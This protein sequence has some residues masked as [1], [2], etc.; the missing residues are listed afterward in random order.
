MSAPGSTYRLQLRPDFLDFATAADLVGYLADLGVSHLYCSPILAARAESTHGYDV[1]DPTRVREELGGEQGLRDLAARAHAHGLGVVADLVPNH[2]GTGPENPLWEEL[3]AGGRLSAAAAVFDVDWDHPLPGARGR[4]VLP[5]LGRPYGEVLHAGELAVEAREDGY[6]LRYHEHDLPLA[7]ETVGLVL[8]AGGPAGLAGS[9]G[10]PASWSALHGLIEA[11]HYRLVH[12][13]TGGS[14]VN[15]RRF[16]AVDDLAAV[17]VEDPDV[18]ER[19][20]GTILRLVADGVLAGLRID[21]PDGL[22]DPGGY[23]RRLARRSGGVWTVAEKITEPGEVLPDW[24]V[25]GTT[26]YEFARDVLGLFV[27]PGFE[28]VVDA[29]LLEVLGER[30]GDFRAGV[31]RAKG[32]VLADD[33]AADVDRLARLLWR[34]AESR[35]EVRDTVFAQCREV[36]TRLAQAMPVYRTY[37]DP[38]SGRSDQVDRERLDR[39]VRVAAGTLPDGSRAEAVERLYAFVGDVLTG[40]SLRPDTAPAVADPVAAADDAAERELRARFPQ[41]SSAAMAK[42]LE[43]T[44]LYRDLR[45]VA[46]NEVGG[47]PTTMGLDADGFHASQ[48]ERQRRQPT[49]MLTTSTHDTKRGED[50]RLRIAAISERGMDVVAAARRWILAEVPRQFEQ[51]FEQE[52][53]Q[54]VER[55][56]PHRAPDAAMQ[57]LAYQTLLGVWPLDGRWP[58]DELRARVVDYLVKAGR[59]AAT[60]TSW[61][62]PGHAYEERLGSFVAWLLDPDHGPTFAHEL[63]AFAH[64]VAEIAIVSGLA[65]TLLRATSPGVP[66]TY[67]GTE[68]WGDDLVDP[69]N[70]RPTDF[71][72]RR[73]MLPGLDRADPAE[74]FAARR[75]G[76]VKAYVLREALRLR[77]RRPAAFGSQ[78]GYQPLPARGERADHVVAFARSAPDG[79]GAVAVAPRLPG[80]IMAEAGHPPVGEAWGDTRVTF[81]ALDPGSWRDVYTGRHHQGPIADLREVCAVLPVALLEPAGT[82]PGAQDT[83]DRRTP[84]GSPAPPRP[85]G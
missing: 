57:W 15:Y 22:R 65:Q 19:T 70:R 25:A 56:S 1:V 61:H 67:Q 73:D 81:P 3:L 8:E 45:L 29:F 50:V 24:P 83:P 41:L 58:N 26:G 28:S 84:E 36:V 27:D 48:A 38:E 54:D 85:Q 63:S 40:R 5:I 59:E 2:V 12:W 32:E 21:H 80:R 68:L 53:E 49:G 43:D 82:A 77:A 14:L 69:D 4:V 17:R 46:L 11:Q 60:H 9:P 35:R 44:H 20:H 47:D 42:G 72:R 37:V 16:F 18:F 62:E 39:A 34:A 79:A 33:L 64:E 52:F 23:F 7:P 51:E 10:E 30:G 66:D 31:V 78:A 13:R 76:R 55:G 74:L 75:D 6:R 71:A